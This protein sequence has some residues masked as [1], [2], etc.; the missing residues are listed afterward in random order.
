MFRNIKIIIAF[1]ITLFIICYANEVHANW[2]VVRKPA[3]EA[4]FQ[5][6]F[7]LNDKLGWAVGDNGIIVHTDN[8]GNEW[9]KQDLNTDTYL[10]T[11]HFADEK[12]GWIVGDDGFIAQTSNGGMTWVHQQSNIMN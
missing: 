12:N 5:N 8:G 9:K 11:V 10:R 4:N 6:V 2:T 1:F 3:W 7:F